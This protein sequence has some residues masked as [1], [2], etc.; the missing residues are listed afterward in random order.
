MESA[1]PSLQGCLESC[2][3]PHPSGTGQLLGTLGTRPLSLPYV[4]PKSRVFPA[5]GTPTRMPP[6]RLAAEGLFPLCALCQLGGGPLCAFLACSL[7]TKILEGPEPKCVKTRTVRIV[8]VWD[9][10]LPGPFPPRSPCSRHLHSSLSSIPIS[11]VS[12]IAG[13]CQWLATDW[14]VSFKLGAQVM[15][16]GL[17]KRILINGRNQRVVVFSNPVYGR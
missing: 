16:R 6:P 15:K 11:R 10:T 9:H 12:L 3:S 7:L 2:S 5:V 17:G 4:A 14:Q 13:T 8:G 1:R